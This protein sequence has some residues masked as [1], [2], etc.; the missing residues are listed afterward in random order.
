M[1]GV[2]LHPLSDLV[3]FYHS[4]VGMNGHLEIDFAISRT[5][6]VD[7]LH[8]AAYAGFG[9]W[10]RSCYGDAS[11]LASGALPSGATSFV[12]PLGASPVTVDR[13]R[14]MED[15]TAGQLIF[16]YTVEAQ[17]GG[18]WQAFS[19]G[20]SIGATRID[21]GT[22]VSAT[23]L[24]FTVTAGWGVPTGLYLSAFGPAPCA[25]APFEYATQ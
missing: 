6:E 17:V 15:Q 14:M 24:R 19:A 12:L 16:S 21:I 11:R 20:V 23:A 1:P 4:S 18:A 7:P 8:A 5:G 25:L 9:S 2:A 13:V 3:Q 22:A 10:I